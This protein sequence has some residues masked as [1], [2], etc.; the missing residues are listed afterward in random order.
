M[1]SKKIG[2]I[3]LGF[4][5]QAM[6]RSFLAKDIDVIG[7]DKYKKGGIGEINYI[8]KC[9]IVFLCLPAAFKDEIQSYDKTSIHEVC[10][11]LEQSK[12]KGIVVLKSTV[13]PETTNKLADKYKN[14]KIVHNPE[15][16]TARSAFEDFHN[17]TH[18]V[19]GYSLNFMHAI[20]MEDKFMRDSFM[21]NDDLIQFY[22]EY[23]PDAEISICSAIESESVKMFCNSFYASKIM[24]FNEYYLVCLKNG[25]DFNKIKSIMLKNNLI[26]ETH[27]DVPH[28]YGLVGHGGAC[29]PKDMKALLS[30]MKEK[31]SQCDVLEN[32]IKECS[33]LRE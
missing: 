13:E 12:Y 27:T 14:L 11:N 7:Y 25:A 26:N 22:S 17:Q 28:D 15:F 18:I 5:G 30:Y 24:L 3:G 16:L 2:I 20:F 32:V 21:E 19:L 31:N 29:Y 8:I 6:L 33:L 1:S 9:D 23:Y 4:V 10:L